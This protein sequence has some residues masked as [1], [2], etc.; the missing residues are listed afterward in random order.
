MKP[1]TSLVLTT[2]FAAIASLT[3]A[4]S[5]KAQSVRPGNQYCGGYK[6]YRTY[7]PR[8]SYSSHSLNRL[9]SQCWRC[10]NRSANNFSTNGQNNR[11]N[12]A[13][14][15]SVYDNIRYR[16]QPDRTF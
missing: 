2:F 8:N 9:N 3:F 4:Q 6:D 5:A 11:I 15:Y 16:P 7:Y 14:G 1:F 13:K 12:H 10:F